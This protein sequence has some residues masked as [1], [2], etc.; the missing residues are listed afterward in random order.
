MRRDESNDAD[1]QQRPSAHKSARSKDGHDAASC[2][3]GKERAAGH[4]ISRLLPGAL[5]P[6]S[7]QP[8]ASP[9]GARPIFTFIA[10]DQLSYRARFVED[11]AC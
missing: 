9:E 6:A 8:P 3:M 11:N 2:P 10:A 4:L 1:H 7:D 5:Q